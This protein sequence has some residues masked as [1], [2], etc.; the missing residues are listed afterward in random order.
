LLSGL[1]ITFDLEKF[2]KY[3]PLEYRKIHNNW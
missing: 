2:E 1:G 3:I